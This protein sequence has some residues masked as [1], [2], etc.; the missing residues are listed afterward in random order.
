M[1]N[2]V[3]SA[4][5]A[6]ESKMGQDAQPGDGVERA[7]DNYANQGNVYQLPSPSRP[8]FLSLLALMLPFKV[9]KYAS[10]AGVPQQDDQ[11]V[12]EFVDKEVN[13]EIPGGNN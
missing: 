6:V 11:A 12:N 3:K 8:A 9:D 2:F 7:A 13:Q 10:E 5:N 4:E 1:D